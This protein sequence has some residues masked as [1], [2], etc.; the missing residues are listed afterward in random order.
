MLQVIHQIAPN[1]KLMFAT[2]FDGG[3]PGFAS[4]IKALADA[5]ADIIVDDVSYSSEPYFQEGIIAS[6]VSKVTSENDVTYLSSAANSNVIVGGRDVGSIEMSSLRPIACP[7]ALTGG[8]CMNFASTNPSEESTASVT[9]PA[10]GSLSVALQYSEPQSGVTDDLDIALLDEDDNL[11]GETDGNN[12]ADG[13]PFEFAGL[14]QP[15]PLSPMVVKIAIHRQ[16]GSGTP[17][18]KLIIGGDISAVQPSSTSGFRT[19]GPT[20]YGHNGGKDTISVAATSVIQ[21]GTSPEWFSSRGPVTHYWG[22]VLNATAAAALPAP[23]VLAKPDITA[24]D[25]ECTTFFLAFVAVGP[26]N[27][28]Y[29]FYGTSAAAPAAAAVSALLLD[30]QEHLSATQV[31]SLLVDTAALMPG[32]VQSSRGAGLA[33]AFAGVNSQLPIKP[34]TAPVVTKVAPSKGQLA[35]SLLAPMSVLPAV[36][37]Y[38]VT[39]SAAGKLTREASGSSTTLTLAGLA[40]GVRY[41]C[42]VLAINSLGDGPASPYAYGIPGG[43]PDAPKITKVKTGKKRGTLAISYRTGNTGGVAI[44]ARSIVCKRS[45][46]ARTQSV[47]KSPATITR[48]K[49]GKSYRCSMR[50]KNA[51]GWSPYSAKSKAVKA[52]K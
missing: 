48:L 41:G 49:R 20:I 4:N 35:V 27:C 23:D 25:G 47:G 12:I 46:S 26:Y 50:I 45:G 15:S 44:S 37:S 18:A 1:A 34:V 7:V 16:V 5:G 19:V 8:S 28:P 22:P 14:D 38:R 30:A 29:R 31:K 36:S 3:E 52:K 2:A 32:G 33:N 42:R 40:K 43:I 17:R 11:I 39:C 6:M 51:Y 9:I 24:S 13:V 10:N 21:A